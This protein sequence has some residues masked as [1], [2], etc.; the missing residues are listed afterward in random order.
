M[1]TTPLTSCT[2]THHETPKIVPYY[3]LIHSHVIP[4]TR[5]SLGS[6]SPATQ[7]RR[8]IS[9]CLQGSGWSCSCLSCYATAI[10]LEEQEHCVCEGLLLVTKACVTASSPKTV[11][12]RTQTLFWK[13]IWW[14]FLSSE[15]CLSMKVP[16]DI[17]FMYAPVS[18]L[19]TILGESCNQTCSF[20]L[21]VSHGVPNQGK[22]FF[23]VRCF[24]TDDSFLK[25]AWV[26]P[27]TTESK[28]KA[29]KLFHN[30]GNSR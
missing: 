7:H 20:L 5:Y 29:Y 18:T 6:L 11:S 19:G 22:L 4:K 10:S 28:L 23:R 12:C 26:N 27:A 21:L 30:L 14:T 3:V 1:N 25:D 2:K 9:M 16:P 15:K 24:K 17:A 8:S 13:R